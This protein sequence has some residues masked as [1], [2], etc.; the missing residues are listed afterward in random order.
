MST[1]LK[2]GW[3]KDSQGN[4]FAPKTMS[5]QVIKDDGTLLEEKINSDISELRQYTN[6]ELAKKADKEHDHVITDINGLQSALDEKDIAIENIKADAANM[7]VA[8]LAEAQ[9]CIEEVK[10][11]LYALEDVVNNKANTTHS[12][13]ITDVT[14]L[15]DALDEKVSISRTINGKTLNEDINLSASDVGADIAGTAN[16]LIDTHDAN[17]NAHNDIR[18]LITALNIKLNNFLDLGTDEE[19]GQNVIDSI[20][21][22][23][24]LIEENSDLIEGITINK[25]NVSDIIDN[26]TTNESNKSLSAAQGVVIKSLIES[27]QDALDNHKHTIDDM[28]GLQN[29]T[30]NLQAQIDTINESVT[31]KIQFII[32]EAD[33]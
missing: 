31:Q 15:Q 28:E 24:S 21:E 29:T 4:K 11:D 6:D 22:I 7:S 2:A 5:S 25:V 32:W 3:L 1:T 16:I 14:N 13:V 27:L 30:S 26:L 12:H 18:Q 19:L 33:D 8:I 10:T 17:T 20:S 9:K 23:V